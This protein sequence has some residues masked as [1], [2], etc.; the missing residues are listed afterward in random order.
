MM[1]LSDVPCP[2]CVIMKLLENGHRTLGRDHPDCWVVCVM[3]HLPAYLGAS[4][5]PEPTT[6][7]FIYIIL[8]SLCTLL[9]IYKLGDY[10]TI[11]PR[12]LRGP[13]PPSLL[14]APPLP[15]LLATLA[16]VGSDVLGSGHPW[17]RQNL[18]VGH[19]RRAAP[20]LPWPPPQSH[21]CYHLLGSGSP[22]SSPCSSSTSVDDGLGSTSSHSSPSPCSSSSSSNVEES[23]GQLTSQWAPSLTIWAASWGMRIT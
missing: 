9:Q 19:R 8:Q 11:T 23:A 10:V 22:S 4:P 5:Q 17:W 6:A 16:H 20:P 15:P 3:P 18:T 14:R 1:R 13:P 7:L 12:H 2:K 21:D